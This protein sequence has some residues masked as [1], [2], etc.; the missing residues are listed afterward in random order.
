MKRMMKAVCAALFLVS[1]VTAASAQSGPANRVYATP[2]GSA[3]QLGIRALVGADFPLPWTVPQGGTG[4][5][6]FSANLPLIGNGTGA[7]AQGTRSGN[8]TV[9]GTTSGTLTSGDGV[10]FDASGNLVAAG[11]AYP[12]GANPS[13]SVGLSAVNGS[14]ITFM[15]SDAA[16][17]LSQ[18]IVPTW[19]GAHTFAPSSGTALTITPAANSL[20]RGM[21]ITQTSPTSGSSAG[22]QFYNYIQVTHQSETTGAGTTTGWLNTNSAALWVQAFTGGNAAG[23]AVQAIVGAIAVN[24]GSATVNL[25]DAV[26]TTGQ[27]YTNVTNPSTSG[28]Y[29]LVGATVVDSNGSTVHAIGV[30]SD[31]TINTT[32]TPGTAV[33]RNAF[34]AVNAG[35]GVASAFDAAYAVANIGNSSGS[36]VHM[37]GILGTNGFAGATPLATTGDILFSD[38]AITLAHIFNIANITVTGNVLAAQNAT[39]SGAGRA[40]FGATSIPAAPVNFSV[41]CSSCGQVNVQNTTNSTTGYS[42]IDVLTSLG[43]NELLITANEPNRTATVFGITTGN[44][45][46]IVTAGSASNGLLF[47]TTTNDPVVFGANNTALFWLTGNGLGFGTSAPQTALQINY[48]TAANPAPTIK[49]GTALWMIGKD[50]AFMNVLLMDQYG[51]QAA[52]SSSLSFRQGRGTA[53]SPTASAASDTLGLFEFYG[54]TGSTFYRSAL[55]VAAATETYSGTAGGAKLEWYTTP[56]TTQAIALAATF[57]ASGGFSVGSAADPGINSI[58]AANYFAGSTAGV[59]CNAGL[60][61]TTR[62]IKGIVTTC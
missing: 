56:A 53:A 45:S 48:N 13:A 9:F 57:H 5:T 58:A 25:P 60:G 44:Y 4:Q 50:G 55:L 26:G 33:V 30:E 52:N 16:P 35:A 41:T 11:T 6:T 31:L 39:I 14:A 37:F 22:P 10:K 61:G 2:N 42:G 17:A 54:Y 43:T 28:C 12:V 40:V 34:R 38:T 46:Q 23:Q 59:T 8:T 49:S 19:T 27:C 1:G 36:F 62:T 15:R 20:N 24:I 3:G 32:G 7:I 29:G 47:G 18:A 21:T 51:G